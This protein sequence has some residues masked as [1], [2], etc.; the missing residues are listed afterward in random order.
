[1]DDLKSFWDLVVDVWKNGL[2]G[3]EIGKYIAAVL[4][5]L[6]FLILRRLLAKFITSKFRNLAKKSETKLDDS[7]M[8]SLERPISFIPIVMGIFF[9]NECL[10]LSGTFAIIAEKTI[11]SLIVFVIFWCFF[12]LVSPL[13]RLLER[14]EEV[15]TPSLLAWM[16]NA[17]KAAFIFIGAATILE[18]WGIKVG[19]IIAGL[20]L[21]GVAVALG[22]QD[23]FKNLI[24]GI[25]IIAERRF[26]LGD[27]IKVPGV[28]EGT[29]ETIGFR[30]T[31]VRRFDLAPVFVPNSKLSDN[32]VIN[33]SAMIY[34]RIYWTISLEYRTTVEQLRKIR[35]RIEEYILETEDFASPEDSYVLVYVDRFS[36]S[37]IDLMLYC[38]TKTIAWA[39]WME[40]KQALACKIKEIVE[41]EG[42]EFAFPSR[43][44]YFEATDRK[45]PAEP[46][47]PSIIPDPDV[48]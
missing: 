47:N 26:N 24:S 48:I 19:P 16:I 2:A 12:N 32:T 10:E 43:S 27:W 34:R 44:V 1:M 46:A 45:P 15:F 11:R 6:L 7:L 23:L 41:E 14:L 30:S 9:A 38:F 4:I 40:I 5:F 35:D 39:E 20:G 36:E 29:V 3:T 28:V 37:S 25:L 8:D 18:I 17:I 13:S 33:F 31:K 22:A 42:A 21:F